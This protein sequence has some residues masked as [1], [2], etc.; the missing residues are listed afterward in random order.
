[1]TEVERSEAIA[2]LES[3]SRRLTRALEGLSEEQAQY[4]LAPDRWSA[5]DCAEHIAAAE[6]FMPKLLAAATAGESV[7]GN[8]ERD[9]YV[10]RS[11]RDRS[12]TREAPERIRPKHR[13]PSL[14]E[15]IRAFDERRAANIDFVRTTQENLRGRFYPHP[16]VGTIDCYQWLLSL[17]AHTDRHAAQIEEIRRELNV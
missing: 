16:F 2:E 15:T 6:V 13:W 8:A 1:M 10:R 7:E 9:D 3:S 11:I 17:A 12:Q 5:L 4:R 14:A